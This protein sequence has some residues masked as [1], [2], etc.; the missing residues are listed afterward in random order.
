MYK[1]KS[2]GWFPTPLSTPPGGKALGKV[3]DENEALLQKMPW[4]HI[5]VIKPQK[6]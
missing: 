3:D 4:N 5:L 6:V 2:G 1:K